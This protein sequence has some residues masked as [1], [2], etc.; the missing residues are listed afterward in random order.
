MLTYLFIS[1][2]D[3]DDCVCYVGQEPRPGSDQPFGWTMPLKD[4]CECGETRL[5]GLNVRPVAK[6]YE[7]LIGGNGRPVVNPRELIGA[8][9]RPEKVNSQPN[10]PMTS[11]KSFDFFFFFF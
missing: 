9:E 11:G 10:E 1:A 5:G 4:P 3:R 6:P 2:D 8:T 7:V